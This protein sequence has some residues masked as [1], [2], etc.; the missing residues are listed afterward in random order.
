MEIN[1]F[2]NT[3]IKINKMIEMGLTFIFIDKE[4]ADNK[5]R[6][7]NSYTYECVKEIINKKNVIHEY[8]YAAPK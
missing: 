2:T 7:L 1:Y 4:E 5:A 8:I 3:G 6:I